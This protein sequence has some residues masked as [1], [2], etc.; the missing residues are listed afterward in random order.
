MGREAIVVGGGIGGLTMAIAL[1]R[2]GWRVRVYERAAAL[3]EVGAGISL[4]PNAVRA[5]DTL[6]LGDAVR[7]RGTVEIAG[8]I[9]AP[10]GRVLFRQPLD[11]VVRRHGTPL[12][13]HR[14]H[15]LEVLAGAVPDG[16]VECGK[17]FDRMEQADLVVG[18]DGIRS[19]VRGLTWP[20]APAPRYAG[21][22]AW[23]AVGPAPDGGLREGGETWGRGVRF[24]YAPL[25]DGRVYWYAT[26]N[27]PEGSTWSPDAL[28]EIFAGWHGPIPA[29][30]ASAGEVLRHD[31]YD[32]DGMP[33][34]ARGTVALVG[35]AAHAMTPNLGQGACQAI[36]DA[37]TLAAVV[38]DDVPAGLRRYDALRRP[39][40]RWMV[41]QSRRAGM[42]AQ[43]SSPPLVAVRDAL[44]PRVPASAMRG[45]L[46][47]ALTWS[48]PA[49]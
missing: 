19:T 24:G 27:A 21:Y 4:W 30:V 29:L 6:G 18:A 15:L 16:A 17:T 22:T 28:R 45:V 31:L 11:A 33:S 37:V 2:R 34:Y 14:A 39:R 42:L 9:R 25:G 44:L 5:L 13:L 35:D 10:D 46:E 43:L 20:D 40:A 38:G 23:R 7:A 1:H 32:L 3:T 26:A 49:A 12:V 48:P 36:E 47:R 41:R 8:A